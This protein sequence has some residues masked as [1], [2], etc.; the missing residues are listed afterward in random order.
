MDCSLNS[1]IEEQ[2]Q[3]SKFVNISVFESG[4]L[5]DFERLAYISLLIR[6]KKKENQLLEQNK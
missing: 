5:Y 1:I 6:D 2:Y 3:L 4:E